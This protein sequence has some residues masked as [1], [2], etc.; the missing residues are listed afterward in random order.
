MSLVLDHF[1]HRSYQDLPGLRLLSPSAK[2]VVV[3]ATVGGRLFVLGPQGEST[4]LPFEYGDTK[5]GHMRRIR[6][7]AWLDETRLVAGAGS[8]LLMFDVSSAAL[9]WQVRV[10]E[11]LPFMASS[12]HAIA[13]KSDGEILISTDAGTI[14]VYSEFGT[15]LGR[16]SDANAP[17]EAFLSPDEELLIGADG[18]Q[19]AAW[20]TR[21]LARVATVAFFGQVHSIQ[22]WRGAPLG[23][24]ARIDNS[25]GLYSFE[26]EGAPHRQLP[27]QPGPPS[28]ALSPDEERVCTLHPEG[29]RESKWD[30]GSLLIERE[31]CRPLSCCYQRDGRLLIGWDDGV[32]TVK[33]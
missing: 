3:A 4:E 28:F 24:A 17:H 30:G 13:A 6:G 2:G 1:P 8:L 23:F 7:I 26:N 14:E 21:D 22:P 32:F 33:A 11:Y 20:Q 29:A 12:I 9:L 10:S 31:G 5:A 19:V 18:H 25:I 27:A 16:I 15:L